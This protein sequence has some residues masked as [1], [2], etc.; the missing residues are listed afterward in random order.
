MSSQGIPS[1]I[2]VLQS[3]ITALQAEV[4]AL[5]PLPAEI[6]SFQAQLSAVQAQI[7]GLSPV[8]SATG[9]FTVNSSAI[10][11]KLCKMFVV[12]RRSGGSTPLH[13]LLNGTNYVT[14]QMSVGAEAAWA[15]IAFRWDS[16]DGMLRNSVEAGFGS[17]TATDMP[18]SA[19]TWAFTFDSGL[20]VVRAVLT[21][22]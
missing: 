10:D 11:G 7:V 16:T 12:F 20:D 4:N 6:A 19:G 8:V 13:M 18:V 5:L 14:V 2:D 3:E 1:Q 17:I 21:A 9:P 15:E 22:Q